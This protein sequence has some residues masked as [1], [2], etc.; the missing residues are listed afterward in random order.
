MEKPC[1]DHF[2]PFLLLG[3]VCAMTCS[4]SD[5]R[6]VPMKVSTDL[7]GCVPG[8]TGRETVASMCRCSCSDPVLSSYFHLCMLF[9]FGCLHGVCPGSVA[10]GCAAGAKPCRAVLFCC[11]CAART[12]RCCCR[13]PCT[14]P[15]GCSLKTVSVRRHHLA[16]GSTN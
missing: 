3:A 5:Y 14:H 9:Y 13:C 11:L 1:Q 10:A 2:S 4:R 7:F 6:P 12:A 8:P 15:A 16:G